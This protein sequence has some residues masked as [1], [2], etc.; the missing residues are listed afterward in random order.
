M[1]TDFPVKYFERSNITYSWK[2]QKVFVIH[3]VSYSDLYRFF[4][5]FLASLPDESDVYL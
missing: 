2:F 4:F 1:S 3:F 5:F